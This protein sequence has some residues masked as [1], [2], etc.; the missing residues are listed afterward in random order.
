M[1]SHVCINGTLVGTKYS[2]PVPV[3]GLYIAAATLVCMLLMIYDILVGFCTRKR[4]LPCKTFK[5]DSITLT[6][7][8]VA[9]KLT[10]DLTTPMPT[11]RDQLSKLCGTCLLCVYMGFIMPSLG[12]IEDSTNMYSLSILV[13]TVIVNICIQISTGVVVLFIPE[14][15]IILCIMLILLGLLWLCAY[16]MKVVTRV[17]HETFRSFIRRSEETVLERMKICYIYGYSCN[18]QFVASKSLSCFSVAGLILFC[19]TVL[20]QAAY[21]CFIMKS[22][23]LCT[24]NSD[25]GLSMPIIVLTQIL[26]V[27]IGSSVSICRW[28]TMYYHQNYGSVA[29]I[30]EGE[31]YES[32]PIWKLSSQ[33]TWGLVLTSLLRLMGL[34]FMAIMLF[35]LFP[36]VFIYSCMES[37]LTRFESRDKAATQE[38]KFLSQDYL[39]IDE[40][41]LWKGLTE[42]ENEISVFKKKRNYL[43]LLLSRINPSQQLLLMEYSDQLGP[44]GES[45]PV[46]TLSIVLLVKIAQVCLPKHLNRSLVKTFRDVYAILCFIEKSISST[47]TELTKKF[48]VAK[49]VWLARD[50]RHLVLKT[51][52]RC[53]TGQGL[54]RSNTDCALAII[55]E[56]KSKMPEDMIY[57]EIS[58]IQKFINRRQFS[59]IKE[60]YDYIEQLYVDMLHVI[61]AQ[62]PTAAFDALTENPGDGDYHDRVRLV[63]KFLCKIKQLEA[64]IQWKFPQGSNGLITAPAS[65]TI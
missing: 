27:I 60:L 19:L 15:I 12:V 33:N 43:F 48:E 13:I 3:I 53:T 55:T 52:D 54:S 6:L 38:F 20:I 5:L 24:R 65:D 32:N 14:H 25:Y 11:V 30:R 18:P 1:A 10:V 9:V 21:R 40:W 63:L 31:P 58:N 45:I 2:S 56:V 23:K 50:F 8:S 26:T 44:D 41:T 59:S 36:I 51:F 29:G 46:S 17:S 61:L 49:A 4:W 42:M 35:I 7:V 47:S 37:M 16:D 34:P 62:F 57:N 39:G 22:E 28:L 64:Q